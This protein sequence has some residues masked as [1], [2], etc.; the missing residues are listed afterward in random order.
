MRHAAERAAPNPF[1]VRAMWN[2]DGAGFGYGEKAYRAW[3]DGAT[4]MQTEAAG[5]WNGRLAKDMA[6]LTMLGQCKDPAQAFEA[7]M[8]YAREAMADYYEESQ[9]MMGLM[10]DVATES[11]V[12]M[13]K[14]ARTAD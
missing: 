9:R 1:D 6:A 7:Q 3:L 5:F 4:R 12:P 14:T 13:A 8:R 11:G 10:R 2:M